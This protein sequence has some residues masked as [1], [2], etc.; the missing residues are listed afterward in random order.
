MESN[1][2]WDYIAHIL[3]K[4]GTELACPVS[5]QGYFCLNLPMNAVANNDKVPTSSD[6]NYFYSTNTSEICSFQCKKEYTYKSGK[7]VK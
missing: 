6:K 5:A 1:W 4:D 2:S 3:M 7:C